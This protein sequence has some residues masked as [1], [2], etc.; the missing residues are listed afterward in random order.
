M[1]PRS[2]AACANFGVFDEM[3]RIRRAFLQPLAVFRGA[4]LRLATAK[5]HSGGA[6]P[7]GLPHGE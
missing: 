1:R 3:R 6:S 7:P 5:A 2:R 4:E